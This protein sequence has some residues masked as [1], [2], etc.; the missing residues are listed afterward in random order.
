MTIKEYISQ[1]F[2]SLGLAFSEV[3]LVDMGLFSSDEE[4]TETNI[5]SVRIKF[6]TWLPSLLT[7]PQSVSEGGL[8]I[9]RAQASDIEK[10][11][12]SECKK[13]GINPVI[14]AKIRFL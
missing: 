10:F 13:L 5:D 4:I 8:S 9:S 6:T 3:D 11:Y 7:R 12:K 14:G 1:R 2:A